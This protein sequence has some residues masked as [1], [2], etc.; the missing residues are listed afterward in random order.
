M[1]AKKLQTSIVL[2]VAMFATVTSIAAGPT[3]AWAV[4]LRIESVT[5]QAQL[6]RGPN[7]VC[8][9]SL[10]WL[11][12]KLHHIGGESNLCGAHKEHYVYD[13]AT[14]SWATGA[15]MGQARLHFDAAWA[16]GKLY[17]IA[18]EYACNRQTT[19]YSEAYDPAADTWTRIA[20]VPIKL[21]A[22]A[23]G[24]VGDKV[25]VFGGHGGSPGDPRNFE[26]YVY[27]PSTKSWTTG[28]SFSPAPQDP[29]GWL[30]WTTAVMGEELYV[31]SS[32]FVGGPVHLY[33]YNT[34][35]DSWTYRSQVPLPSGEGLPCHGGPDLLALQ[36]HVGYLHWRELEGELERQVHFYLYSPVEDNWQVVDTSLLSFTHEDGD[37]VDW[38]QA[39]AD[40][41][42]RGFYLLGG[43]K[44]G[45][46]GMGTYS[47]HL[48]YVKLV[49]EPPVLPLLAMAAVGIL[50][51]A[52]RRRKQPA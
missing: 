7:G 19:S 17:G 3:K 36:D 49:P 22:Y 29:N 24:G 9:G 4:A 45:S 27:E 31:T 38:P 39:V 18:G 10:G 35:D 21:E 2:R 6:I 33:S 42:G 40:D 50:A 46:G 1:I 44:L 25:Y 37:P 14:D 47:R 13:P 20:D 34:V 8:M 43:Q 11:G 48:Q 28:G 23:A 12:G 32:P 15:S 52:W 30:Q 26:T 41:T 5:T 51:Y 16:G